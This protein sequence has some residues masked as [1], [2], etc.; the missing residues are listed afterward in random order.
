MKNTKSETKPIKIE[1]KI[2]RQ[3][4]GQKSRNDK[5]STQK[6]LT[7][8]NATLLNII[9]FW[10]IKYMYVCIKMES[11]FLKCKKDTKNIDP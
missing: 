10:N 2:I 3:I 1:K 5:L 4:L 11:Y 8:L 9:T 7:V 6:N